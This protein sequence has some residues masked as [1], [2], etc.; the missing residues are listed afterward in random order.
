MHTNVTLNRASALY[1]PRVHV[2]ERRRLERVRKKAAE[3][4]ARADVG[5]RILAEL[6]R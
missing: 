5:R 1:V 2:A 3:N 4:A 6:A